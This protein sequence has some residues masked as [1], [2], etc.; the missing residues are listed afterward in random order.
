MAA[1]GTTDISTTLVRNTLGEDNN[2]VGLLCTSDNI[3]IWAKFKPHSLVVPSGA[4]SGS[5][6]NSH[7]LYRNSSGTIIY[8]RPAGGSADPYRL[9]DFRQYNHSAYPP[10]RFNFTEVRELNTNQVL[11]APY[12]FII[13]FRYQFTFQT[14]LGEIL[15]SEIHPNTVETKNT[16]A[17]GG[18][19][20]I[21]LF[22]GLNGD[23]FQERTSSQVFSGG[24]PG[25]VITLICEGA[26]LNGFHFDYCQFDGTDTYQNIGWKMEDQSYRDDFS[27]GYIDFDSTIG[28]FRWDALLGLP[29][30]QLSIVNNT[31]R[32]FT[33]FRVTYQWT[34]TGSNGSGTVNPVNVAEIGTTTVGLTLAV[35]G[36]TGTTT[37]SVAAQVQA[38][39]SVTSTW[40][41]ID[42][43]LS[44]PGDITIPN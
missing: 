26:G 39:D 43:V 15:P 35:G 23:V 29:V 27:E 1:L 3:N 21:S 4:A 34:S 22:S 30:C 32:S 25:N 33:N 16:S 17:G 6:L 11:T 10:L 12:Q 20:G 31:G 19:G 28:N 36:N 8:A 5:G 38:F 44:T 41:T 2:D 14:I 9:G 40:T 13:G 42:L 18:Y 7:G 24:S 37:Y